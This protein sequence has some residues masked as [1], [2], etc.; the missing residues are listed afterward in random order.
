MSSFCFGFRLTI[1][2]L[3]IYNTSPDLLFISGWEIPLTNVEFKLT[4]FVL[5]KTKTLSWNDGSIAALKPDCE[6][7]KLP[8]VEN[9]IG[10]PWV[11]TFFESFWSYD[12][13]LKYKDLS[14]IYFKTFVSLSYE[15]TYPTAVPTPDIGWYIF[16]PG[17]KDSG[18]E[19]VFEF[20]FIEYK[21]EKVELLYID[22]A[23]PAKVGFLR[24]PICA[25]WF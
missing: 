11:K 1:G 23:D 12:K 6:V 17:V 2:L 22:D 14:V 21:F 18:D 25:N 24:I 7:I 15:A 20:N 3:S 4:D 10:L 8:A 19:T 9:P 16:V 13:S 5:D